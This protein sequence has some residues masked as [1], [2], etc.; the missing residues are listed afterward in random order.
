MDVTPESLYIEDQSDRETYPEDPHDPKIKEIIQRDNE[1]LNIAR[2]L[3]RSN[4]VKDAKDLH[5]VSFIFQHG[6]NVEDYAQALKLAMKAVEKGWPPEL[7]LVPHATDRLMI[8]E[9][10]D[11]GMSIQDTVQHFGTQTYTTENGIEFKPSLDG[12]LTDDERKKF[13]L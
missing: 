8:Q 3:I 11:R 6:N 10:L 13:K 2:E 7:S 1:R 9:Q 5:F 4:T 12:T